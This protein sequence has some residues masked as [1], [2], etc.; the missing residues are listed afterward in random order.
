MK[1][2][3]FSK[4]RIACVRRPALAWRN[5]YAICSSANCER[6]TGATL[7]VRATEEPSGSCL[8]LC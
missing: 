4:A 3:K 1:R 2:S 7:S 5:A 8:K 6:F